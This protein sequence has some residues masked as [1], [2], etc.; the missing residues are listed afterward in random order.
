MGNVFNNSL[1]SFLDTGI[2]WRS[3]KPNP[4]YTRQDIVTTRMI[5]NISIN[6]ILY[7]QSKLTASVD[8]NFRDFNDESMVDTN[9]SSYNNF[10]S[11]NIAMLVAKWNISRFVTKIKNAT[12]VVAISRKAVVTRGLPITSCGRPH[13]NLCSVLSKILGL[14]Y[15]INLIIYLYQYPMAGSPTFST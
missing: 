15:Y 6:N 14:L 1:Q 12:E 11:G 5:R 8:F 7:K 10:N 3:I 2:L 4:N 13:K 9:T